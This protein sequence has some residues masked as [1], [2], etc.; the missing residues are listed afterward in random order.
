M[1]LFFY[2]FILTVVAP[3]NIA[4]PPIIDGK[5][6]LSLFSDLIGTNLVS[7]CHATLS[8]REGLESVVL[9]DERRSELD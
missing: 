9:R 1:K 4:P 7:F 5:S 6:L 8:S 2:L 3:T